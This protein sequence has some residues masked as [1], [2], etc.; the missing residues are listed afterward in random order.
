MRRFGF[1]FGAGAALTGAIVALAAL[2]PIALPLGDPG[3]MSLEE[4]FAPPSWA[5]PFGLDQNG[6]DVLAQIAYGARIS[7]TVAIFAVACGALIGLAVGS[8]AGWRGGAADIALMRATEMAQA[9]PGFLL[10]LALAA[11]LGPSTANVAIALSATSWAGYARLV[12]GE[13]RRLKARDH[14]VA[15]IA[16]GAG[17]WRALAIHVWPCL[18]GALLAQMTFGMAAAVIGESSL[19][20]LGLGAPPSVPTWGSLLSSGRRALLEAP[21]LSLFPGLA[22]LALVLGFNLLGGGLRASFNPRERS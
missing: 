5:H 4:R 14:V 16:L 7:L 3:K 11:A 15:A 19:S 8:L 13:V 12:R 20:F 6:A 17:P 1:G 9:F 2:G 21:H 22:I 18:A 10:A